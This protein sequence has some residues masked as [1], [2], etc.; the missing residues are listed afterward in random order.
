MFITINLS[1]KLRF[2]PGAKINSFPLL[3]GKNP[4]RRRNIK[5]HVKNFFFLSSKITLFNDF[6]LEIIA[7]KATE[8][9]KKKTIFRNFLIIF[10]TRSLNKLIF[11][12]SQRANMI[13][14]KNVLQNIAL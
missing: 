5:S 2:T 7:F 8:K 4:K 1:K 12:D 13:V 10:P 9:S 6:I 3:L 11:D 14:Q